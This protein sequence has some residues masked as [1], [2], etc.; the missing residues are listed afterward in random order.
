M[1]SSVSIILSHVLLLNLVR[2]AIHRSSRLPDQTK[3]VLLSGICAFELGC[4]CLEQGVLLDHYGT[5]VW[6]VSLVLVVTWQI[7]G[8]EGVSPNPLPHLLARN[9]QGL[10]C[11]VAMLVGSMASYR[12]MKTIWGAEMTLMHRGRSQAISSEVCAL[13]WGHNPLY[14]VLLCELLGT[15]LLTLIPRYLLEH[16][17]LANNDPTKVYRGGLVGVTVLMVVIAGMNTSG[18][19][20]NP[21]LATL[22]VGGCRDHSWHQH[23]L[24]YWVT[25]LLGAGLGE[26]I[27]KEVFLR[28]GEGKKL[29]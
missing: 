21:T 18:A 11:V 29:V 7:V 15:L 12:H 22:M 26:L 2:K 8:W 5:I 9:A 14:Q 20:F 27:Y 1:L 3:P 25:P 24:I 10:L 23:L 19:M 28:K 17:T 6:A 16:E 13:P 4:V